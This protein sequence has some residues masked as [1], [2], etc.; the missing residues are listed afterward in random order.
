M[1]IDW[2]DGTVETTSDMTHTY[3]D[4]NRHDIHISGV[5]FF[6]YDSTGSPP[7]PYYFGGYVERL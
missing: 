5:G 3:A 4:N 6:S 2:G 1:P 7:E